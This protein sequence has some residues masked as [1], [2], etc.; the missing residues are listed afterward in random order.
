M[1]PFSIVSSTQSIGRRFSFY[2]AVQVA[3]VL[4]PGITVIIGSLLVIELFRDR[5]SGSATRSFVQD[6]SGNG[7]LLTSLFLLAA[8]YISGYVLR[9]LAFKLLA[10]LESF[11]KLQEQL[12]VDPYKRAEAHFPSELILDCF[13]AHPILSAA[14]SQYKARQE[15]SG[16]ANSPEV[17]SRERGQRTGG[18]HLEGIDYEGFVYAKLWIRNYAPGFSIDSIEAE[19]NILVSGLAPG[20]LAG[21]AILAA[22]RVV[23]WSIGVGIITTV[24]IWYV[25]L[26]SALRLRRGEKSEAIRNIILDYAMRLAADGYQPSQPSQIVLGNQSE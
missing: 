6:F 4:A 8:G 12:R 25:L 11:P 19:I 7:G 9:E 10:Q 21:L 3:S 16:E 26:S 13:R 2:I 5:L 24:L 14:Y 23:W 22:G 1:D 17:N 15:E 20:V 18:G